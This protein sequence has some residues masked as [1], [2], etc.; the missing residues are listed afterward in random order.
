[1]ANG[2]DSIVT[3][4]GSWEP[5]VTLTEATGG[6]AGTPSVGG[7]AGVAGVAGMAGMAGAP[8]D[9]GAP[10]ANSPGLYLEAESGELSGGFTIGDD[11]A[12]SNGQYIQGPPM[13]VSDTVA[14]AAQAHYTF[15]VDK[16]GDYVI[17]GRIYSPDISSNRFWF[18]VDGG[19]WILWR[20]T[21]GTI[22]YWD[23][24]H[25]DTLYN[26][27]LHFTLT[28]GSHQLFIAN[29][30][31]GA[32]LDRLY[33]TANGDHPPGNTT[34][35]HPPH[36]IDLGNPTCAPSCGV[37]AKPGRH[38]SCQCPGLPT[39]YAYDCNTKACCDVP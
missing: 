23:Y 12:A 7:V 25:V 30:V 13:I 34:K 17:W 39:F 37:Q 14:G 33:I 4:V 6:Q 9:G 2:C 15:N 1:V 20:I 16:D 19:T 11:A 22:W 8:G 10:P 35:C 24:F 18:K 31:P 3:P 36:S 5:V 21:V 27:V 29:S 32:R 26:D 28:A 38:V